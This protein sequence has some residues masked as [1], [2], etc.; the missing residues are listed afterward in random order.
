MLTSNRIYATGAPEPK[1]YGVR[2]EE[3]GST[4]QVGTAG[5]RRR[6]RSTFRACCKPF[7][8]TQLG[9]VRKIRLNSSVSRDSMAVMDRSR[10]ENKSCIRTR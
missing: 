3:P 6:N 7:G 10:L 5:W 1:P 8:R 4:F 2:E 9:T